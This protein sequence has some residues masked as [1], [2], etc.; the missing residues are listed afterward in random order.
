[1]LGPALPYGAFEVLL[2]D[3]LPHPGRT[4]DCALVGRATP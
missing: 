3:Q 1:V 2:L 4:S